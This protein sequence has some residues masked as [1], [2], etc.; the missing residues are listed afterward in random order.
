MYSLATGAQ[1]QRILRDVY[2]L[3]MFNPPPDAIGAGRIPL[4]AHRKTWEAFPPEKWRAIRRDFGVTQVLAYSDWSLQLPVA[5]QSRR[6]LLYDIP[7][8]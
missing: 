5:S 8:H 1:M 3:D 6:L 7:E 4:Q 2:G